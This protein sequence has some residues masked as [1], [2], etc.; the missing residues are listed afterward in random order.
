MDTD[1]KGVSA[2]ETILV[3][4]RRELRV[5]TQVLD[6]GTVY[7]VP[8][9]FDLKHECNVVVE[10]VNIEVFHHDGS[11]D[12]DEPEAEEAEKPKTKKKSK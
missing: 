4:P 12:G 7:R 11:P 10:G 9:D 8:A 6:A 5:N 1:L 2:E 3:R